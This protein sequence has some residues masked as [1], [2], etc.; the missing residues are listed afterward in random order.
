[1][2]SSLNVDDFPL[3]SP[4]EL[5]TKTRCTNSM[6]WLVGGDNVSTTALIMLISSFKS[7]LG[8]DFMSGFELVIT[9]PFHL[10]MPLCGQY[11]SIQ[12]GT[13]NLIHIQIYF[14]HSLPS[15]NPL[16]FTLPH[17]LIHPSIQDVLLCLLVVDQFKYFQ[18]WNCVTNA[19]GTCESKLK[20]ENLIKL[21]WVF[22]SNFQSNVKPRCSQ[23]KL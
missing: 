8:M 23:L 22:S 1:M 17:I 10:S 3:F 12:I 15:S 4:N 13:Q 21:F 19:F 11:I 2:L 5:H 14:I 18:Q 9:A 7:I 20:L 6:E 16:N